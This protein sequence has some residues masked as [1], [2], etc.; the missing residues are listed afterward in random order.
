MTKI[1]KKQ[2]NNEKI[3]FS[4]LIDN[5]DLKI[6][7]AKDNEKKIS[8]WLEYDNSIVYSNL[9]VNNKKEDRNTNFTVFY[10]EMS[11]ANSK[12]FIKREQNKTDKEILMSRT[13]DRSIRPFLKNIHNMD[14]LDITLSI[15]L[16]QGYSNI[17]LLLWSA[18]TLLYAI[19]DNGSILQFPYGKK[20][21]INDK[22]NMTVAVNNTG[23]IMLEGHFAKLEKNQIID[24]LKQLMEEKI[25]FSNLYASLPSFGILKVSEISEERNQAYKRIERK[26]LDIRPLNIELNPLKQTSVIFQRGETKVLVVMGMYQLENQEI[27]LMYRF[28]PF[29]VNETGETYGNSR[30]EKGHGDFAKHSLNS[31]WKQGISYKIISEVF[32]CNGSS[33]MA[34]VC[35]SS[36]C[37]AMESG[38]ELVSGITGGKIGNNFII[39]L[40][41]EEDNIS[42]CD[43]KVVSNENKQICGLFMDTKKVVTVEDFSILLDHTTNANCQIIKYMK[44]QIKFHSALLQIKSSKVGVFVGKNGTHIKEMQKVLQC[45]IKVFDIGYVIISTENKK[46]FSLAK[47]IVLSFNTLENNQKITAI[48]RGIKEN[49]D[50]TININLGLLN[51]NIEAKKAKSLAVGQIISGTLIIEQQKITVDK[52]KKIKI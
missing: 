13:V 2:L 42:H 45:N 41:A 43:F 1:T 4:L 49:E 37:L 19:L 7:I 28:H 23:I 51:F 26:W 40:T 36:L 8:L 12:N 50:K 17:N 25:N 14:Q 5:K 20:V 22:S 29:S 38:E 27:S 9:L 10:K 11:Y 16:L 15:M 21:V 33:S 48:I 39:D 47:D 18:F 3:E 24:T 35:G 6:K 46:L 34:T 30:R 32:G 44:S 52:I 31:F